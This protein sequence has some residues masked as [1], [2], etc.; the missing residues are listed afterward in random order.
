ML[1]ENVKY[2]SRFLYF[3][4]IYLFLK[5]CYIISYMVSIP[6]PVTVKSCLYGTSHKKTSCSESLAFGSESWLCQPAFAF[7]LCISKLVFLVLCVFIH[8]LQTVELEQRLLNFVPRMRRWMW[9]AV[10]WNPCPYSRRESCAFIFFEIRSTEKDFICRKIKK[11]SSAIKSSL[12]S[13]CL[14]GSNVTCSSKISWLT[15]LCI[16]LNCWIFQYLNFNYGSSF[17]LLSI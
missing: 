15:I 14:D 17:F 16:L 6:P 11:A 5:L 8:K 3:N 4:N 10:L 13:F 1:L 2:V 12:K 9:W 7:W